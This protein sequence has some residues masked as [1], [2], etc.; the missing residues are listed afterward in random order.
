MRSYMEVALLI[1]GAARIVPELLAHSIS[2]LAGG[3]S[4]AVGAMSWIVLFIVLKFSG[5]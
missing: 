4:L 3:I 1:L 5:R 2:P